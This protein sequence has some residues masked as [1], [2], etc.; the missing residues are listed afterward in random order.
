V[1][2]GE[3]LLVVRV[4]DETCFHL[5]GGGIEPGESPITAVAREPLEETGLIAGKIDFLFE[6]YEDYDGSGPYDGAA[7]SVFNVEARGNVALV[8]GL[9]EF[10]W[11]DTVAEIPLQ[12]YAQRV[13]RRLRGVSP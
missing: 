12:D 9:C 8:A 5:P 1:R 7:H 13:L 2:R 4:P 6:T 3:A 10:V 11:A